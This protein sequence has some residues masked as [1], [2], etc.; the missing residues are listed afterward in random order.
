MRG[1]ISTWTSLPCTERITCSV[2]W[3]ESVEK[4]MIT[5]CT[6]SSSTRRGRSSVVPISVRFPF[7]F[8]S[9]CEV[10]PVDEPDDVEPVLGM[11]LDLVGEQLRDLA[12][13]DDDD[14]LHVRH[15][16]A[17]DQPAER[18]KER[19]ERDRDQPEHDEPPEVRVRHVDDVREDEV[20]PGSER[21][22]L[23]HADDVVDG[24]VVGT[25]L[26]AVVEAVD[27]EQ[28]DPE[29]HRRREEDDLPGRNDR[30][31]PRDRWRKG[32]GNGIRGN[33]AD[34]VRREQESSHEPAAVP[35]R[36]K[37]QP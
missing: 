6:S 30:V 20:G 34:D 36:R 24:R 25:L 9:G 33:E 14:V 21:E 8:P 10:V 37:W 18:A 27:V 28:E 2:R 11:L 5:R 12:R 1:T 3:C 26:V 31:D 29:R 22:R 19:D 13:P 15:L 23:E 16:T 32:H 7:P 35:G 17:S 4:A